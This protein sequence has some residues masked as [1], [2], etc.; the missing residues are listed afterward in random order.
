M[1]LNKRLFTLD[2]VGNE[3]YQFSNEVSFSLDGETETEMETHTDK[4]TQKVI[5]FC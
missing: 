2:K 4:D 1:C 5:I 3:K